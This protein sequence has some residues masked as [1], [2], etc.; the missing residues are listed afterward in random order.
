MSYGTTKIEINDDDGVF[1]NKQQSRQEI[2]YKQS[3]K[4]LQILKRK[5][6]ILDDVQYAQIDKL[7]RESFSPQLAK[8]YA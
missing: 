5:G 4:F 6:V 8:V 1:M 7:N 3:L 2:N